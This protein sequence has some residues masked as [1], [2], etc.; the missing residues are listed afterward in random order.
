[1]A[2]G[3]CPASG[4]R[5]RLFGARSLASRTAVGWSTGYIGPSPTQATAVGAG[6]TSPDQGYSF[7][8]AEGSG[9]AVLGGATHS[10]RYPDGHSEPLGQGS[11]GFDRDAVGKLI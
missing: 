2:R 5:A 9:S 7:W 6:T 4:R 10:V 1:A 11:V 3:A 8:V